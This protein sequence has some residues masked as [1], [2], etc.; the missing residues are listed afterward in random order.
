M[1][2]F[3]KTPRQQYH[4]V[5]E[6]RTIIRER[7]L[8]WIRWYHLFPPQ[9]P[10]RFYT[11][12]FRLSGSI[13]KEKGRADKC[14]CFIVNQYINGIKCNLLWRIALLWWTL[15]KWEQI[16]S[17]FSFKMGVCSF[18]SH[19]FWLELPDLPH[20]KH[21]S[22]P[23]LPHAHIIAINCFDAALRKK[24]SINPSKIYWSSNSY[25]W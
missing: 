5:L 19:V 9:L 1:T 12:S 2:A 21:I 13:K 24:I 17:C 25:G 8:S 6:A 10:F 14:R 18:K 11:N 3:L 7:L 22:L 23:D 15:F 4:H 16:F 20:A